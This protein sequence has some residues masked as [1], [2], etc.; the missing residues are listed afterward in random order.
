[1]YIY[2]YIERERYAHIYIHIYIYIYYYWGAERSSPPGR[3]PAAEIF[4]LVEIKQ[5]K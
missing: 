5:T 3:R 2:I 4:I 1:M